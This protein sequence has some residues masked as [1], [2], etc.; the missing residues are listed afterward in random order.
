MVVFRFGHSRAAALLTASLKFETFS[1]VTVRRV[2]RTQRPTRASAWGLIGVGQGGLP[3]FGYTF[4]TPRTLECPK[5]G[6]QSG[7]DTTTSAR[8][9]VRGS[10]R[11]REARKPNNASSAHH[12]ADIGC[13]AAPGADRGMGGDDVR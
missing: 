11:S 13:A 8:R 1:M 10:H 3:T 2:D 5:G 12:K 7:R 6:K 9:P 4:P